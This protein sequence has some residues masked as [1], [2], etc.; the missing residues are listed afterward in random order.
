MANKIGWSTDLSKLGD[1]SKID[2]SESLPGFRLVRISERV[3]AGFWI[4][5][6]IFARF[7][8][9]R[10]IEENGFQESA[11]EILNLNPQRFIFIGTIIALVFI[12]MLLG[13]V[14]QGGLEKSSSNSRKNYGIAEILIGTSSNKNFPKGTGVV[15]SAAWGTFGLAFIIFIT[16][17]NF[18]DPAIDHLY[19][20]V[21]LGFLTYSIMQSVHIAFNPYA[22]LSFAFLYLLI[23][24][25]PYFFRVNI[26]PS[27]YESLVIYWLPILVLVVL[28]RLQK[29]G[30]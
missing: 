29:L 26:I 27:Q 4:V 22:I 28:P 9:Q 5:L 17:L 23:F 19:I 21:I 20:A 15:V 2:L 30:K 14:I 10:I 25:P 1:L 3:I 13:G 16:L 8:A 18:S 24:F 7:Y 11:N 12:L 6:F